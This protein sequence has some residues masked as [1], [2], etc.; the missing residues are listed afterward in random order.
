M[1]AR[2]RPGPSTTSSSTNPG[3]RYGTIL[4]ARVVLPTSSTWRRPSPFHAPVETDGPR[5]NH[6]GLR[7]RQLLPDAPRSRAPRWPSFCCARAT[8]RRTSRRRRAG[9]IFT[10]VGA[11]DFAA[12]WIEELYAEGITGGCATGPLRYCPNNP[13]TRGQMA[14][15]LLKVYHGTSYA[16]PPAQGVFGDV[17]HLDAARALDRGARAPL[18]DR[19]LR[20]QRLLPRQ[21]RHARPDGRLHEQDV[22]PPRGDPLPRAGDLGP[23]DAD[24]GAAARAGLTCRGSRRRTPLPAR[25]IRPRSSRSGR[26]TR[27]TPATTRATATTTPPTGSRTVSSR[28]RSTQPDQLRQRVA[29]ALHKIVVVSEDTLPYP[30]QMA[31]YLRALD[32]NAFG[33]YRDILYQVTLNPGDGRLPEHG[34][35]HEVR[36]E[37]ELRP[38]DHAALLDRDGAAEPGRHDAERRQRPPALYDQSV[39]DEFKRVYTGW[40]IDQ[41]PCPRA[42]RRRQCDDWVSPMSYDPDL[43]DTDAKTLF[44]GFPGGP[45]VLPAGPDGRPGPE[46]GDRRDLQPPERRPVPRARAHPQPRDVEPFARVRRARGRLLQR[47]RHRACAASLWAVVKAILLDPEA[48]SAPTDPIYGHLREPVLYINN[49]LRAFHAMSDDRTTQTDGNIEPYARDAGPE[50][51]EAADG[52]Q[53]LPAVLRRAAGL[54]GRARARVRDH[55]LADVPEA[56]ELRQP[57][58]DLGRHRG[59]PDGDTPYGTSLDFAELQLLAANPD[60]LVDGSTAAAPRHD[61]RRA[62][63]VDR[64]RPSTRS[65]PRDPLGRA[66]QALYLVGVVVAIPG[67]EVSHDSSPAGIS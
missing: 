37:R 52:L 55:E 31:P 14:A 59:R 38:R 57:D 13:V 8:A 50:G 58:D 15:F 25:A 32:P 49:V 56:R 11:S 6:V 64:R 65:T 26:P 7:R 27:R 5:R 20:R 2:G 33:N 53:L 30:F 36:P 47:Q 9:T 34:H 66:Q 12:D 18:G 28:T 67:T 43:H 19:G 21:L 60:N 45:V 16:P 40:Y 39:I 23:S 54:G 46:P 4:P 29:W 63:R 48:R 41:V 35:V 3:G 42:Q 44:A 17:A 1:P 61:V 24:V 22:P 51:L 10:D 62:A